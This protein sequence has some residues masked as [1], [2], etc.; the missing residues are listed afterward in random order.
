MSSVY[1][2]YSRLPP[3]V[4]D[5]AVSLGG[6]GVLR[7]RRG[8]AFEQFL[9][10]A[11]EHAFLPL[12]SYSDVRDEVWA[13]QVLPHW[14]SRRF[15]D[16]A[17]PET[18]RELRER[19]PVTNKHL[20][21]EQIAQGLFRPMRGSVLAHTS[22][23]T[24]AGLRFH[25]TRAVIQRQWAFWWRY[26]AA[27]GIDLREW[28]GVFGGRPVVPTETRSAPFWRVNWPGRS[29]MFSVYHL[30]KDRAPA[31]IAEIGRRG[32]RWL[33]GYP[34]AIALL[35]QHAIDLDLSHLLSGIRCVTLGA[36]NVLEYQRDAIRR[37][38]GVEPRQHYGQAEGVANI[39]ECPVGTLHVDEDYSL[40]EFIRRQ[41]GKGYSI[42][43]TS[44]DN[45]ATLFLR[46]DTGD[47]AE[48]PGNPSW[49]CSCGRT[50]RVVSRI[51]GRRED[52]II[53]SDGSEVGRLDHLFKDSTGIAEAQIRQSSP[54]AVRI[55]LVKGVAF[56]QREEANIREAARE[57]FGNR[58]ALSFDYVDAIPRSAT[59]KLR[60]VVREI[61]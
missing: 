7:Q 14:K 57:R 61:P 33:H 51:D 54:G 24:G 4:Q 22:G 37:A 26:R 46:Y 58:L 28:S 25:V 5:V 1:E 39:S 55:L 30:S 60:L 11:Q 15:G 3:S 16:S 20:L 56:T 23:T 18:L 36:E 9:R 40:V 42:V 53:L 12:E 50:G 35:A 44:I 27:L 8:E 34:S 38:F 29:V 10:E 21:R 17:L 59:G 41:D 43:G 6:L 49:R 19:F 32:L 31:Y 48:L 2:I 13:T 52:S 47:I 45:P